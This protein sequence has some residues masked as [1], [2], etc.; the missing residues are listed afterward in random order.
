MMKK[1]FWIAIGLTCV[2]LVG[3]VGAAGIAVASVRHAGMVHVSV[4]EVGEPAINITVPA[5]LVGLAMSAATR[6]IPEDE[7]AE[8]RSEVGPWA[9]HVREVIDEFRAMPDATIVEVLD[10]DDSV[11]V[12]KVRNSLVIDVSEPGTEVHVEMPVVLM[13]Q[14]LKVVDL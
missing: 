5:A 12:R 6:F 11:E 13:S 4:Q 1:A 2:M 7:R 9:P 8:I 10:G 14:A 3:T